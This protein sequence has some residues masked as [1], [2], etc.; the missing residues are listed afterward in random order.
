MTRILVTGSRN[1]NE[2]HAEFVDSRISDVLSIQDGYHVYEPPYTIVVGDCPSG[3]DKYALLA[4]ERLVS[5]FPEMPLTI[6]VFQAD[7]ATHGRAAGPLRNDE[8]VASGADI[9]LAFLQN[10]EENRGTK[11]CIAA[12]LQAGIRVEEDLLP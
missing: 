3:A 11:H 5:D 1:L 2:E 6:E 10:G 8:M 7:W 9:C 12:A 4:Y